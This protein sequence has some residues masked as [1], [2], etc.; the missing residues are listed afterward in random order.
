MTVVEPW[1][2]NP[3][4]VQDAQ[5]RFLLY[6][7][8]NGVP[9][10]PQKNCMTGADKIDNDDTVELLLPGAGVVASNEKNVTIT[11]H[12][13]ETITGPWQAQ[14]ISIVNYP[15]NYTLKNT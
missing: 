6:T 7:L 13:A 8:G 9:V 10:K 1:A 14:N 2:H 12:Y 4:V 5:G 15:T 11:M 3:Q